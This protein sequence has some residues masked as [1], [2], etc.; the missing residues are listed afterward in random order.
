MKGSI[1][2]MDRTAT[3]TATDF[4]EKRLITGKRRMIIVLAIYSLFS[5]MT[6]YL[7][8][9][10]DGFTAMNLAMTVL[11]V[12]IIYEVW[13]GQKTA[14]AILVGTSVYSVGQSLII[15]FAANGI[16]AGIGL[17][18]IIPFIF[19]LKFLLFDDCVKEFLEDQHKEDKNPIF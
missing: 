9:S 16:L 11:V 13:K 10:L 5:A 19:I 3:R 15:A 8:Y 1:N 6:F 4:F 12:A 2:T 14:V 17:V 7:K 18:S